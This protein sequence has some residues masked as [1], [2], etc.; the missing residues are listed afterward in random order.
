LIDVIVNIERALWVFAETPLYVVNYS[1]WAY[2]GVIYPTIIQRNAVAEPKIEIIL[3]PL[4]GAAILYPTCKLTGCTYHDRLTV[5][6]LSWID[7]CVSRIACTLCRF[8]CCPGNP[9]RVC[10]DWAGCA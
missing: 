1:T 10:T 2:F 3:A 9:I 8:P 5:Q 6:G 7:V 4:S